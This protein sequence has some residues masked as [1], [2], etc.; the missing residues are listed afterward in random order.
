MCMRSDRRVFMIDSDTIFFILLYTGIALAYWRHRRKKR[1][2]LSPKQI[3]Q[4]LDSIDDLHETAQRYRTIENMIIDLN[5]TDSKHLK[6][7]T[8]DVPTLYEGNGSRYSFICSGDM[9]TQQF[10]HVA[11]QERQRLLQELFAK[12]QELEKRHS[13]AATLRR[14]GEGD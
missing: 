14:W 13:T 6:S 9:T 10:K 12:T 8:L 7:I 5:N 2:N 1:L 3:I 4:Y 11:E